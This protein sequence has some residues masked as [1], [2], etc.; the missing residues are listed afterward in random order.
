MNADNHWILQTANDTLLFPWADSSLSNANQ[1]TRGGTARVELQAL[2]PSV[3]GTWGQNWGQNWGTGWSDDQELVVANG[4]TYAIASDESELFATVLIE[5]GG[6]LTLDGTLLYSSLTNNG[7]FNNNGTTIQGTVD[8]G[9]ILQ[10]LDAHAGAFSIVETLD[11]S[12]YY[13]PNIPSSGS[14]SDLAIG[15]EPSPSLQNNNV[16]GVWGVIT[17]VTDLRP[18]ALTNTMYSVEVTVLARYSQ[19]ADYNTMQANLKV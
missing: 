19:Y 17:N 18:N 15:I 13:R 12:L 4:E 16:P 6:T 14:I 11:S 7:T 2:A 5:S 3:H 1:I 10:D 8:T 9:P